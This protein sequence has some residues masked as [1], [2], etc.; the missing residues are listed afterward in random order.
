MQRKF[1][2]REEEIDGGKR[3]GAEKWREKGIRINDRN[4]EERKE[5]QR[6]FEYS[7]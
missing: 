3:I 1:E 4:G 5:E 7:T 2:F 6:R